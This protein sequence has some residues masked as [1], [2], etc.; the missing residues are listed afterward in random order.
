MKLKDSV[1]SLEEVD[2]KYR[3]LYEQDGDVFVF[4][5]L[6]DT[7]SKKKLEEFRNTNRAYYKQL[8][9]LK[10]KL[11]SVE[12]IDPQEYRR[13]QELAKAKEELKVNELKEKGQFEEYFNR[14]SEAMRL[15]H[16]RAIK[17]KDEAYK[18][19]LAE[20]S[21]LKGKLGAHLI[22]AEIQKAVLKAGKL[23]DGAIDD[24][25]SRGRRV[26]QLD[27]HNN[28]VPKR[29]DEIAYGKDGEVLK[30][31][32]WAV[33]LIHEAPHLFEGS[34][35]GGAEGGPAARKEEKFIPN[36]DPLA[37]G[38]NLEDIAKG[39]VKVR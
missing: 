5:G 26:W 35:G 9:E 30:M 37:F 15:E 12:G 4:R 29:G 11:K 1:K 19:A 24:V 31:E 25:L 20:T 33:E 14:R 10:I 34:K 39:K 3:E 7:E 13:L 27:E 18:A 22:D 38:R 16:E 2:E 36:N 23:R 8:E 32:E 28:V 21:Q 6:D 17:A